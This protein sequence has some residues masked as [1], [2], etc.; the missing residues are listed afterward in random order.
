MGSETDHLAL[1]KVTSQE[2]VLGVSFVL[3]ILALLGLLML[4]I[5]VFI[6]T[7]RCIFIPPLVFLCVKIRYIIS[8]KSAFLKNQIQKMCGFL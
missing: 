2:T 7:F 5:S 3:L 4:V 1:R 8:L 6:Q